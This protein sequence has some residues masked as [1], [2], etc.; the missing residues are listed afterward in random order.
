MVGDFVR[1]HKITPFDI[2]FGQQLVVMRVEA[3]GLERGVVFKGAY[4]RQCSRAPV[5]I[6]GNRSDGE[7]DKQRNAFQ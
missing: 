6:P 5:E 3:G 4:V 7:G 1:S 2:K